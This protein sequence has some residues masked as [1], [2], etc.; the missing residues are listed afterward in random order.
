MIWTHRHIPVTDATVSTE[1]FCFRN[2]L[3]AEYILPL[4]I[5]TLLT[6]DGEV[7]LFAVEVFHLGSLSNSKAYYRAL[8]T[9]L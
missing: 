5:L 8:S 4:T 2:S 6:D 1:Q 9:F 7:A 3:N